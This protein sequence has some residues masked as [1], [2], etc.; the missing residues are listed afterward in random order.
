MKKEE[1]AINEIEKK[2]LEIVDI[3]KQNFSVKE[4]KIVTQK[5][6]KQLYQ[7][8][9]V[10]KGEKTTSTQFVI[11]YR[12]G[13]KEYKWSS[14]KR[15]GAESLV[16]FIAKIGVEEVYNLRLPAKR[17][18]LLVND[19][20]NEKDKLKYAQVGNKF[21]FKKSENEEKITLIREIIDKLQLHATVEK[22]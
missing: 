22:K 19:K 9:I 8:N 10:K 5:D 3:F 18:G 12:E 7:I 20:I 16:N 15:K 1:Q 17:V 21:I 13:G 2:W 4:Y 11:T 6:K 14:E